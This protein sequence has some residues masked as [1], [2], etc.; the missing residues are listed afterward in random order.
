MTCLISRRTS[1]PFAV[2]PSLLSSNLDVRPLLQRFSEKEAFTLLPDDMAL[3]PMWSHG[4]APRD[5]MVTGLVIL[6][7]NLVAD[8]TISGLL[9]HA[10]TCKLFFSGS[11]KIELGNNSQNA[12][13]SEPR[14]SQFQ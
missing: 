4:I 5:S 8:A 7:R 11:F 14:V 12:C 3:H 9:L 2:E 10:T 1:S 13:A 6:R